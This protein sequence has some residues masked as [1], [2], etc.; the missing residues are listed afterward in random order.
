MADR[1]M[2]CGYVADA[3]FRWQAMRLLYNSLI[4]ASKAFARILRACAILLVNWI[5]RGIRFACVRT[6]L[7]SAAKGIR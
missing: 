4:V 3:L 6:N 7:V 2:A 1:G 5:S